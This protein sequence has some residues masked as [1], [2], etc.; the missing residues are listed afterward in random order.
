LAGWRIAA[1]AQTKRV[2]LVDLPPMYLLADRQHTRH[3]GK[4]PRIRAM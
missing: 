4:M 3:F 1:G 2:L